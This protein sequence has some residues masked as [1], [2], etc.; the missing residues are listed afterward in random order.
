MPDSTDPGVSCTGCGSRDVHISRKQTAVLDSVM[1]LFD[2]RAY[3]CHACRKRFYSRPKVRDFDD[4]GADEAEPL[5][6]SAAN[7]HGADHDSH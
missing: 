6:S 3:R 1:R 5:D 7:E 4:Y 2:R